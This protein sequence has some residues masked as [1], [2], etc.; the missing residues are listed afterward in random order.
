MRSPR[1]RLLLT[2][3]VS[4]AGP[5]LPRAEITDGR[6]LSA[7]E[8]TFCESEVMVLE[9][10]VRLYRAQG[11]SDSEMRQRNAAPERMLR[12]CLARYRAQRREADAR[13]GE[14]VAKASG[15][16]DPAVRRTALSAVMCTHQ[17][18]LESAR[19]ERDA[20]QRAAEAGGDRARIYTLKTEIGLLESNVES[21]RTELTAL[22]GAIPC[23]D[24]AVAAVERCAELGSDEYHDDVACRGD[25]VR[26]YL[27][28]V[29]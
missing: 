15:R 23:A 22:G 18:R 12:E 29:R 26:E 14:E 19:A 28:A 17:R 2:A 21:E 5:A 1:R 7:A 10:R 8:A 24:P 11:L 4:L 25:A 27:R 6:Q 3:L 20:Q 16:R 13:A 9:G